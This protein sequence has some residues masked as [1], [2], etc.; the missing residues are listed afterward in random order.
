MLLNLGAAG[1]FDIKSTTRP[2]NSAGEFLSHLIRS[3]AASVPGVKSSTLT[4]DYR[5][6]SFSSE[7]SADNDI[8]PEIESLQD[9]FA[10]NFC[11]PI[12]EAA[13]KAGILAGKFDGIAG[14]SA[15]DFEGRQRDYLQCNWQGPVSRSINP[16]DDAKAARTRIQ[17]GTSSPQRECQKLGADH[18]EIL[19]EQAQHIAE[20]EALGLPDDVWQNNLG[21]E[22][23]DRMTEPDTNAGPEEPPPAPTKKPATKNRIT[24]FSILNS[25]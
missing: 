3:E 22:Q 2:N 10:L 5:E 23:I 1:E 18:L 19:Q 20:A 4:G 24:D 12:F 16:S 21:I 9:L 13:I 8:W 6:S 17:N 7:R 11:Q 15:S 14:F 25:A